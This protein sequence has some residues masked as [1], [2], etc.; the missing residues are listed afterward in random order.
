MYSWLF[1]LLLEAAIAHPLLDPLLR[2][3]YDWKVRPSDPA[4][5]LDVCKKGGNTQPQ[6]DTVEVQ[7]FA[8]KLWG[9]DMKTKKYEIDGYMRVWYVECD[10]SLNPLFSCLLTNMPVSTNPVL[11]ALA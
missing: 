6:K 7:F 2:P 5:N 1:L 8:N 11:P 9:I 3:P 10:R 4:V